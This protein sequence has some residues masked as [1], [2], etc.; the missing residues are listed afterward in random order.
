[1]AFKCEQLESDGPLVD[2]EPSYLGRFYLEADYQVQCDTWAQQKWAYFIAVP[3]LIFWGIGIP[4][5]A[6]FLLKANKDKL[7][8]HDV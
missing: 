4:V 8:E 7:G 2:G 6:Y 5:F 1:M 3:S